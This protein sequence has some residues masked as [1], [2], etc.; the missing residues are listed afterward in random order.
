M[1]A[2]S[3]SPDTIIQAAKVRS[4]IPITTGTK[5]PDTLSASFWMGALEPCA[6]STIRMIWA[7]TVSLPILAALNVNEPNLLMV[8]PTTVSPAFF[9]TGRLSPVSM[10]SSIEVFPSMMTPSTGTFS[11]GLTRMTSPT[12]T[13]SMGISSSQPSRMTLA[14]LAWSPMSFLMASDVLPFA[15]ASRYLPSRI[16]VMIMADASKYRSCIVPCPT[17]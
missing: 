4:A 8:A 17:S 13:S 10:D 7:R 11:P 3:I 9:S 15:T 14:V 2:F 6:S 1:S 5:T 12:W 16:S